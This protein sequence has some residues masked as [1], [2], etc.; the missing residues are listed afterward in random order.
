MEFGFYRAYR[1][2]TNLVTYGVHFAYFSGEQNFSTTDRDI[3]ICNVQVK[4]ERPNTCYGS[5]A[6]EG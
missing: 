1:L 3:V 2:M 4:G 6:A 5:G